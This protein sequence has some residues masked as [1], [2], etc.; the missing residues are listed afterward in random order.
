MNTSILH[1]LNELLAIDDVNIL[2]IA[3]RDGLPIASVGTSA[4]TTADKL[5]AYCV[6]ALHSAEL[7]GKSLAGDMPQGVLIELS[8]SLITVEPLGQYAVMIAS[9]HSPRALPQVRQ[10]IAIHGNDLLRTI[11]KVSTHQE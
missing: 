6:A 1:I 5:A 11:D 10:F 2:V 7:L 3:G 9:L 4:M 8:T